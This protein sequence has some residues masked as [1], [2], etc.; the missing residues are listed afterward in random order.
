MIKSN[1]SQRI[2]PLYLALCPSTY[3]L[4]AALVGGST[5]S[6]HSQS[7]QVRTKIGISNKISFKVLILYTA[8]HSRIRLSDSV[9][10][11]SKSI[12]PEK[13]STKVKANP[14]R[15]STTLDTYLCMLLNTLPPGGGHHYQGWY[16]TV[17]IQTGSDWERAIGK[18]KLM[19][20]GQRQEPPGIRSTLPGGV[21]YF[22]QQQYHNTAL[23]TPQ[24][25]QVGHSNATPTSRT[26][27]KA[28]NVCGLWVLNFGGRDFV[29]SQSTTM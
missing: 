8:K 15:V 23:A 2:K 1:Q 27:P 4:S 14:V 7:T 20:C 26:L 18:A 9:L 19:P 5:E 16:D 3:S 10:R 22:N 6:Y 13:T 21:Q 17:P 11:V 29:Y 24:P 12:P 25:G 28:E